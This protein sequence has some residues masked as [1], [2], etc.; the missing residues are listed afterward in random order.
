[1]PSGR[2]SLTRCRA[3]KKKKTMK[4]TRAA[5][6]ATI[7]ELVDDVVDLCEEAETE[8]RAVGPSPAQN[9]QHTQRRNLRVVKKKQKQQQK[10]QKE[11][12]KKKPPVWA[13]F[14]MTSVTIDLCDAD[15]D[16]IPIPG[17]SSAGVDDVP[18]RSG[19]A[20]GRTCAKGS[21]VAV[22]AGLLE[23]PPERSRDRTTPAHQLKESRSSSPADPVPPLQGKKEICLA[24]S[25]GGAIKE[26]SQPVAVASHL[27]PKTEICHASS[28]NIADAA[29][30]EP[31]E[32]VAVAVV[33][34][35]A[36][37]HNPAPT[38]HSASLPWPSAYLNYFRR[39]LQA[40]IGPPL[41][42]HTHLFLANE[43][44]WISDFRAL[45]DP[46]AGLFCRLFL[47]NGPWFRTTEK[48]MSTYHEVS[49]S[50]A[51]L[52]KAID[53]LLQAG[54]LHQ[55]LKTSTN[56]QCAAALLS[57]ACNTS[58]CELVYES[59]L[60]VSA[61]K[62]REKCMRP[63]GMAKA[64][65]RRS[66]RPRRKSELVQRLMQEL[67]RQL[68]VFGRTRSIAPRLIAVLSNI[69]NEAKSRGA[70]TQRNRRKFAGASPSGSKCAVGF[71]SSRQV[72]A[73]RTH[74]SQTL[75]TRLIC[76]NGR[77]ARLFCRLEF[78]FSLGS[79]SSVTSLR[80]SASSSQPSSQHFS[81]PSL[82]QPPRSALMEM[83][84]K[85]TF[86]KFSCADPLTC[87]PLFSGRE[88]F[89]RYEEACIGV[90]KFE[91]AIMQ[92]AVSASGQRTVALTG[93]GDSVP[94]CAASQPCN[95]GD[96]DNSHFYHWPDYADEI[97][98]CGSFYLARLLAE[99]TNS[100]AAQPVTRKSE[101][102]LFLR[103]YEAGSALALIVWLGVDVVQKQRRSDQ[104]V[105]V[106]Q[107]MAQSL[108]SALSNLRFVL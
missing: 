26:P 78:L 44:Q 97:A 6:S 13:L 55:L 32:P 59:L 70:S 41:T 25:A 36:S 81:T 84:G 3:D 80:T 28:A 35:T 69:D 66:P 1:M 39:V 92:G 2:L 24:P 50:S 56:E 8:R 72:H 67:P 102:L 95:A 107:C 90:S 65:G 104:V 93:F 53:E 68:D 75:R 10:K 43:I 98:A 9:Q 51:I 27:Q 5:D 60:K 105:V 42:I 71:P 19:C 76:L 48:T 17:S 15:E 40:T 34:A 63:S 108:C 29:R 106:E 45:S 87:R 31:A 12:K 47:R 79:W 82:Q 64:S 83:F 103:Q 21:A 100:S 46:A 88:A 77:R 33:S 61:K 52:D 73:P 22:A 96:A 94:E 62:S 4:K 57:A 86:A 58:V 49:Q 101:K 16:P 89:V 99:Q 85:M 91:V 14:S 23:L 20:S 18:V 30:K 54:F 74:P 38:E 37:G 11:K 7:P